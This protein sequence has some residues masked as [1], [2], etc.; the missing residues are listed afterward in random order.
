M[1]FKLYLFSFLLLISGISRLWGHFSDLGVPESLGEVL[2]SNVFLALFGL[3]VGLGLIRRRPLART[4]ALAILGL[5]VLAAPLLVA[6]L[7]IMGGPSA[8]ALVIHFIS[9]FSPTMASDFAVLMGTLAVSLLL[10]FFLAWVFIRDLRSEDLRGQF[11]EDLWF[12]R[13]LT[14]G[15]LNLKVVFMMGFVVLLTYFDNLV[16][17]KFHRKMAEKQMQQA[18]EYIQQLPEVQEQ[19]ARAQADRERREELS[20]RVIWCQFSAD[21]RTL[22]LTSSDGRIHRVNLAT[23]GIETSDL[24]R[25]SRLRGNYQ[26]SQFMIGPDGDTYYEARENAVRKSSKADFIY[27]TPEPRSR[28]FLAFGSSAE[29]ALYFN[30]DA[31]LLEKRNINSG[32]LVWQAPSP[33]DQLQDW[34]YLAQSSDLN[35][36][37]V[38]G[39]KTG[40]QDVVHSFLDQRNGRVEV[41]PL[42]FRYRELS[43]SHPGGRWLTVSGPVAFDQSYNSYKVELPSLRW[44]KVA[45]KKPQ[46]ILWQAALYKGET[47]LDNL[48]E[49]EASWNQSLQGITTYSVVGEGRWA[50]VFRSG[51]HHA[52]LLDLNQREERLVL[53]QTFQEEQI[54]VHPHCLATSRS[55][56]LVASVLGRQLQVFW[57]SEFDKPQPAS[58][59]LTLDLEPSAR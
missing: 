33:F 20:R 15:P 27:K 56:S 24:A 6:Y 52:S 17:E 2:N 37:Y 29:E 35:W 4:S 58:L 11:D 44:T 57:V 54:G 55:Q 51:R 53:G 50:V 3:S 28:R 32:D 31:K 8:F 14:F 10:W 9:R 39:R 41:L 49:A 59:A 7:F 5:G 48:P 1:T 45:E 13:E 12:G 19:V 43:W 36:L 42:E 46:G 30:A 22:F 40:S 34:G 16:P 26:G 25:D 18:I 21:E 38:A 23:G 47:N